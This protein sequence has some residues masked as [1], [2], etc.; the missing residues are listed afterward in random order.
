MPRNITVTFG[1]GTT[2]TYQNAP[3]DITPDAVQA[4][5]E[6]EFSKPVASLD[7]GRGAAPKT[8]AD[9][10]SQIPGTVRPGV[11]DQP[12]SALDKIRGGIEAGVSLATAIPAG[13]VGQ[14]AGLGQGVMGGKYGTSQGVKEAADTASRVT[15][16][17][18]YQP[19][20]QAGQEYVQNVGNALNNSGIIGVGLPELNMLGKTLPSATR[21]IGDVVRSEGNLIKGAVQAPL[22]AR[23]ARINDARV[24]QSWQNAPRI[25]AA[26]KANKLGI[27]LDP[28]VSN[29]TKTNKALAAVAGTQDLEASLSKTNMPKWNELIKKDLG[30]PSNSV[31]D[32][33]AIDAALDMHSGP[34]AKVREIP[35]LEADPVVLK[36][37]E[38][39]RI[40]KP[41]IGGKVRADAANMVVN[42]AL[43]QIKKGLSGSEVIDNIRE[44]RKDANAVYKARDMGNVIEP[45]KIAEAD[46]HMSV[47]K[48]LEDLIDANVKDPKVISELRAAR[49]KQA[50]IFDIDRSLDYA[51]GQVNPATLAKMVTEGKKLSGVAKE[52]GEIAANFPG[53][54]RITETSSPLIPQLKRS[55]IGGM[56]GYAVGGP[57]GMIAGAGAGALASK[58]ISK[59]MATPGYQATRAIP[60]DYR[61]PVNNLRPVQPNAT[62]NGLVPYDYSQQVL[63]PDQFPNWTYGRTDPNVT[64]SPIPQGVPQLA[65]PSAESTM[66]GVQQR[67]AFDYNMQRALDEQNT[68]A[69]AAQQQ[70]TRKPASREMLFDLDPVT[71]RL[72]AV[73]Q[74]VK[75][76]TP[77]IFMADTGR[78]LN[79]AAQKMASGQTFALSA[80]E[81]VAWTKTK[82]DLAQIDPGFSKLSDK[83]IAGKA[84][85]RQWVNDMITKARDKAAAFDEISKRATSAQAIRDA[86]MKREQMLD[87]MNDLEDAL[88]PARP[89]SSGGQGP[90]TRAHIRN[91]LAPVSNNALSER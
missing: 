4:R 61:P 11:P 75:G 55:G 82:A 1:D 36:K 68:A 79:S 59:A 7:G 19:R 50:N 8:P 15:S 64:V 86:A 46:T 57:V 35:M 16:A 66:K 81:R 90:K 34:A 47:A 5:A 91:K 62:P 24:A 45:S 23:A 2:H 9:L 52:I 77:E 71:G 58:A 60:K 89:T 25:E 54:A 6:Q 10:V 27:V 69:Q 63:N 14:V 74:G 78:S 53:V 13:V 37:I 21:A 41:L 39:L 26:Q 67:R 29:P 44:M 42:D 32:R 22:E 72:K 87:L 38:D 17:M 30:L 51:T 70:A 80:E 28:A 76:A 33:A 84:M 88:R 20:G 40:S 48:A 12:T 56:A 3:D 73:D 83:A 31:L 18:T 43:D 49:A 85:D 65:A